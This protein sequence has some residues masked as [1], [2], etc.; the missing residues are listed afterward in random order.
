MQSFYFH[1]RGYAEL[2][3]ALYAESYGLS[4]LSFTHQYVGNT[5]R[6]QLVTMSAR[7][8][9]RWRHFF[10]LLVSRGSE[11]RWPTLVEP[12]LRAPVSKAT[13]P[14]AV[15]VRPVCPPHYPG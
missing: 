14:C 3:R 4:T 6:T 15:P 10:G 12:V 1:F 11:I 9:A 7:N 5:F 2:D 13:A 8:R